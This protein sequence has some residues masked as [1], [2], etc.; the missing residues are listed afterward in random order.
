[1][2]SS[3]RGGDPTSEGEFLSI[4]ER[5]VVATSWGRIR[6]EEFVDGTRVEAGTILGQLRENGKSTPLVAPST[7][8]F[9]RWLVR[10]GE[11]VAPGSPVALLLSVEGDE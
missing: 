7:A 3:V 8:I 5:I 11:R 10:Q 4:R 6:E 1:M 2:A 9:V